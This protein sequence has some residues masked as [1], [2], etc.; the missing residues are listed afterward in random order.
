MRNDLL[1]SANQ[2][3]VAGAGPGPGPGGAETL[4]GG[5]GAASISSVHVS[6]RK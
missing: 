4:E 6:E 5:G 3:G 1:R 2:T